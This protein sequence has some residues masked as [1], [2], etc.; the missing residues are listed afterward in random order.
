MN[1]LPMLEH[2]DV[3]VPSL[4]GYGFSPRPPKSASTIGMSQS[5]GTGSCPSLV[6][7]L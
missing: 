7:P 6:F 3:V 2:F 4:P 5:A 1:M